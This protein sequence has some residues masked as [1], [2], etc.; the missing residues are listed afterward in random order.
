MIRV[1]VIG[2]GLCVPAF[3]GL[4]AS[5]PFDPALENTEKF[6]RHYRLTES[7]PFLTSYLLLTPP[8]YDP[9]RSYP[10]ILALHGGYK[11]SA[12]AFVAA[13]WQFQDRNKAFVLMPMAL[14]GQAWAEPGAGG[15]GVGPTDSLRIAMGILRDVVREHSIDRGRI[16]VTGSSN[17]AVGTFA[18]LVHYRD[19]FAAGVPVNGAWP[20]GG[21]GA[22]RSAKLA[23][24]HGTDDRIASVGRMRSLVKAVRAAGGQ[25]KFVEMRG[26]G[27]D[28]WPAYRREDLWRWLFAQARER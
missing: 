12:A 23:I 1:L 17:G 27:H 13:G 15:R 2:I 18:A 19:V 11:R 24:Y 4:S 6:Q 8:N 22:L 21:A 25:P 26:V 9:K 28:S 5:Y 20:T 14:L 16:Y 3:I 10:L 7:F